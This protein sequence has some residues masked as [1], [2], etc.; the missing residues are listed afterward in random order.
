MIALLCLEVLG[1]AAR[2]WLE[3]ICQVDACLVG[4]VLRGARWRGLLLW[5]ALKRQSLVLAGSLVDSVRRV[6]QTEQLFGGGLLE[7]CFALRV[8]DGHLALLWK[9]LATVSVVVI[10]H[11]LFHEALV[12]R[13]QEE[14]TLPH[15]RCAR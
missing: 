11:L 15:S 8:R 3:H 4:L 6:E 5:Q 14:G 13:A 9:L 10:V 7:D 12:V 1:Q 2:P